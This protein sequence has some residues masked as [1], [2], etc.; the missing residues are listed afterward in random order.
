[1]RKSA[2]FSGLTNWMATS[3]GCALRT[4]ANNIAAVKNRI[5]RL[6]IVTPPEIK[7]QAHHKLA[8]RGLA[9]SA[10][11]LAGSPIRRPGKTGGQC[12]VL[13]LRCPWSDGSVRALGRYLVHQD[14]LRRS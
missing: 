6:F 8:V 10:R 14:Q 7:I 1:M 13:L 3:P 4:R 5:R 2:N 12:G 9:S 11:R